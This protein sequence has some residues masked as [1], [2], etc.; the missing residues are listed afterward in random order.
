MAAKIILEVLSIRSVAT[1]PAF[2]ADYLIGGIIAFM[3]LGY[4]IYILLHPEKF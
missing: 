1:V 3:I 4:L 2:K